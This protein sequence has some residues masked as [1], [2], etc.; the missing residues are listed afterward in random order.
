ML[1]KHALLLLSDLA[2][3]ATRGTSTSPDFVWLCPVLDIT[4]PGLTLK[5]LPE[6][7]FSPTNLIPALYTEKYGAARAV[8]TKTAWAV[9]HRAEAPAPV[10][11]PVKK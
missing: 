5:L 11:A 6:S 2:D 4:S 8:D 3:D 7:L 10:A 9:I 1:S